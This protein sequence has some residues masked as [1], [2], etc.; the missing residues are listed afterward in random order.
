MRGRREEYARALLAG[1]SIIEGDDLFEG[2]SPEVSV[3]LCIVKC[4]H[5]V[6]YKVELVEVAVEKHV[7]EH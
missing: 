2:M 3:V 5:I 4:S 6:K 1:K 7:C